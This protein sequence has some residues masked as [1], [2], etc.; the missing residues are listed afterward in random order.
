MYGGMLDG[1]KNGE[2]PDRKPGCIVQREVFCLEI[3]WKTL[4]EAAQRLR[5]IRRRHVEGAAMG[6]EF[7]LHRQEHDLDLD[8]LPSI[9][10]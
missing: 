6:V 3:T 8:I 10:A 5:E 7:D 4:A 2:M 1:K 9:P